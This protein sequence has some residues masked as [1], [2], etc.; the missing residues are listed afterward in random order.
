MYAQY[1]SKIEKVSQ[2]KEPNL[3]KKEKIGAKEK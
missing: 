1:F 3:R 2:P